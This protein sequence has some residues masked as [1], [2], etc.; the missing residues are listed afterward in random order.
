[1]ALDAGAYIFITGLIIIIVFLVLKL[2][3]DKKKP[4]EKK[5]EWKPLG[6]VVYKEKLRV[7]YTDN[8]GNAV[9]FPV[10]TM[11]QLKEIEK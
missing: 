10:Y 6:T 11:K 2:Y 4:K 5:Q 9:H 3:S 1:M 7:V 8:K